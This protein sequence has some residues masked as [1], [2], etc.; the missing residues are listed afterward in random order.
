MVD[1]GGQALPGVCVI[2]GTASCT[3]DKPHTDATGRWTA[4]VPM[5]SP[6][7]LWDIS[8]SKG[9]YLTVRRQFVLRSGQQVS[10]G[11]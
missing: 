3:A 7:L 11:R 6:T 5:G 8:L 10:E 2:V 9:G 4:D 1:E